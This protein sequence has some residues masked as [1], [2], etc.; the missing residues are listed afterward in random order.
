MNMGGVRE[1]WPGEERDGATSPNP[2]LKHKHG[3]GGR[4]T[5]SA[6]FIG[7]SSTEKHS[8]HSNPD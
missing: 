5:F 2:D 3:L 7:E 4:Y 1:C 6:M 8:K